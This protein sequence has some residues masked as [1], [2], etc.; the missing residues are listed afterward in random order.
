MIE[1]REEQEGEQEEAEEE[2]GDFDIDRH[3][4]KAR[5]TGNVRFKSDSTADELLAALDEAEK[6]PGSYSYPGGGKAHDTFT[7]ELNTEKPLEW[8]PK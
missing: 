8:V 3:I 7:Q 2:K 5:E 1:E 6:Q 4:A